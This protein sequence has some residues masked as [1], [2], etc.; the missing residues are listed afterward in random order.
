MRKNGP[1]LQDFKGTRFQGNSFAGVKLALLEYLPESCSA[2]LPTAQNLE[3]T[4]TY[5]PILI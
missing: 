2:G 3:G 1:K 5:S 4:S